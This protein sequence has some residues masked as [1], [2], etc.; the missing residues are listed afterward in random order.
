MDFRFRWLKLK[1]KAYQTCLTFS[2]DGSPTIVKHSLQG[3]YLGW[4]RFNEY[5]NFKPYFTLGWERFK[6]RP[7]VY[8]PI[9]PLS[10]MR[11]QT[12]L[13][14][15]HKLLLFRISKQ[16]KKKK[17]KEEDPIVSAAKPLH[18]NNRQPEHIH[19]ITKK[20]MSIYNTAFSFLAKICTCLISESVYFIHLINTSLSI[21]NFIILHFWR[22]NKLVSATGES[23]LCLSLHLSVSDSVL[24]SMR[25]LSLKTWGN[26]RCS[27][28]LGNTC[29]TITDI[30]Q[31]RTP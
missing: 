16:G 4:Q 15:G 3:L 26:K 18:H 10:V 31:M 19:L 17:F 23:Y 9:E 1:T 12:T 13:T 29:Q 28:F 2:C 21:Q 27:S 7:S 8:N 24:Y 5:H 11:C 30:A 6:W 20:M 22:Y 14:K 25:K